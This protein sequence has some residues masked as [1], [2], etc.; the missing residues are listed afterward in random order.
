MPNVNELALLWQRILRTDAQ[1][2]FGADASRLQ[3]RGW[4]DRI[5]QP[6]YVGCEYAQGG[7]VFV[8]MNPGGGREKDGPNADDVRQYDVLNRLRDD[9]TD[10]MVPTFYELMTV[11]GEIMPGWK[12]YRNFV[13]PVLDSAG[14]SFQ[15]V[16]YFNL[17]K[18]R[19]ESSSGLNRLYDVSW[20]DHVREQ[21]E[22][23]A[24]STVIAVGSDAGKAF[25]RHHQK[26]I[27][28][29]VIP[30]VIGNNVG[31]PGREALARIDTWFKD[32][33]IGIREQ[34]L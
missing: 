22:L 33:P 19:T 1:T 4:G 17:L 5:A 32:H 2:L 18:W 8:S 10:S 7:L 20:H 34:H 13:A 30:R 21:L 12:I 14:V 25:R 9:G 11:L 28:F 6:G 29:D 24:P 26:T 3:T 16:A 23:L 27:H 15:K 31:G